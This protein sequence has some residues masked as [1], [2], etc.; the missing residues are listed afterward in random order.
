MC[1]RVHMHIAHRC[2]PE[3]MYIYIRMTT[4]V[5]YPVRIDIDIFIHVYTKPYIYTQ[6][7][8]THIYIRMTTGV[9]LV[10]S[11]LYV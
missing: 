10:C 11:T 9:Q 3:N 8:K 1:I 7:H 5:Q 4:G 6:N 2:V